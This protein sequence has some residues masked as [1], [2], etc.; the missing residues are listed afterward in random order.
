MRSFPTNEIK[1]S[2]LDRLKQ[3]SD[4]AEAFNDAVEAESGMDDARDKVSLYWAQEDTS[5]QDIASVLDM[6]LY[7]C[8]QDR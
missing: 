4:A 1:I 5:V 2:L 8:K 6:M 3:A 7:A